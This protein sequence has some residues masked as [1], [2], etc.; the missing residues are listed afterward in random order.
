MVFNMGLDIIDEPLKLQCGKILPNRVAMAPLTNTQSNL[1]GTLHENEYNY[2]MR[3]AGHFG[4]LS[5][6]A[7]YISEEGHVWKGQLGIAS[8]K[9]EAGLSRLAKDISEKKS[10]PMVQ[11]HHGGSRVEL[12]QRKISSSGGDGIHAAT[13]E[14]IKRITEDFTNAAVRAEKVGFAGV[15]I[16][17]A[18]GYIFTQFLAENI[19]KRTDEYGGD[20]SGR[21]RFLLETLRSVRKAVSKNFMVNVRI[22][23]IDNF[24]SNR[25]GLHLDDSLEVAKWLAEAGTDV[26]HLSLRDSTGSGPFETNKTPVVTA[27]CDIV[28]ESTK[29]ATTGGIWTRQ[30]A[31]KTIEAGADIIV[32]GKASIIHPNWIELSKAPDFKPILPPWDANLLEKVSISKKFIDYMHERHHLIADS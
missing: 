32:L 10:L 27:I 26:V 7:T 6:C 13:I 12:G 24:A 11:L 28:P 23:P 14:D 9:H 15:E 2:L 18:N 8:N 25:L 5:T 1:D 19:N 31:Q 20:I 4:L 22:S 16:H 29:I 17:G 30:D 21:A 3:R